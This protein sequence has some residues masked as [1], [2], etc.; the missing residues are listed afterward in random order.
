MRELFG[1]HGEQYVNKYT[2][3][4]NRAFEQVFSQL[5]EKFKNAMLEGIDVRDPLVQDLVRQHYE[6]C[7]GFWTPDKESYKSLALSYILPS[8]YRDTYESVAEGLGKYHYEA[9]V[10]FA[11]SNL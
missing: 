4:E 11:D 3:A 10:H 7:L 2:E 9:V 5:T 8:P 1:Q 6:F